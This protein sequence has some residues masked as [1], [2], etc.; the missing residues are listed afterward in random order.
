MRWAPHDIPSSEP[1]S[2]K[3]KIRNPFSLK[4]STLHHATASPRKSSKSVN[5][6][7]KANVEID[8]R[9][10]A[11]QQSTFF[12]RL[13]IELRRIVYEYVMGEHVVHLTLSTKRRYG[14]FVCDSEE[15]EEG[16]EQPRQCTCRVLV[17][18]RKGARLDRASTDM[19]R[20]CKLMY[21]FN[22]LPHLPSTSHA[23]FLCPFILNS[24]PLTRRPLGIL[25][26][27]HTSTARISSP[28]ST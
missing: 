11:Q 7:S 22:S 19:L 14:H 4:S 15:G 26:P 25:K 20:A 24:D 12:A 28:S 17:G 10:H 8:T 27:Y 6:K 16:S 2:S 13:P 18:G 23:L 21:A 9:I 5:S 1:S 3:P